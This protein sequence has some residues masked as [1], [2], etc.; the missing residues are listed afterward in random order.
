AMAKHKSSTAANR[1][2]PRRKSTERSFKSELPRLRELA[3]TR[4][5]KLR[6]YYD[7]G[8]VLIRLAPKSPR[9]FGES[10][11]DRVADEVFH[12]KSSKPTLYAC[13][14][15]AHAIR[16]SQLPKLK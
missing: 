7:V 10:V 1:S 14:Q 6:W 9:S 11:I 4:N 2:A 5:T 12:G 8:K 3:A 15:F 13:R 16:R